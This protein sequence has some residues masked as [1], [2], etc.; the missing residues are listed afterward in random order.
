[1]ETLIGTPSLFILLSFLK[2]KIIKFCSPH[3][4]LWGLKTCLMQGFQVGNL[5]EEAES[6]LPKVKSWR[7]N[8]GTPFRKNHQEEENSDTSTPPAHA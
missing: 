6:M 7:V 3:E 4:I 2:T 8:G 1:M 5:R